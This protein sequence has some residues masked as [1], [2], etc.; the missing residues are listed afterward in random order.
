ME[1]KPFGL[2]ESMLERAESHIRGALLMP[3]T[4][5]VT[6]EPLQHG[7]TTR[8]Q[9]IQLAYLS[10]LPYDHRTYLQIL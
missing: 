6:E 2:C 10:P 8:I 7:M 3:I 4:F 9:F 1:N 5:K